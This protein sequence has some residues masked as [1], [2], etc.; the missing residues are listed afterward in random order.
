MVTIKDT[1]MVCGNMEVESTRSYIDNLYDNHE[2]K[3]GSAVVT[4]KN[5]VIGSQKQKDT[6]I[7]Q[8]VLARLI[9]LL[10]DPDI[11]T[12][13]KTDVVYILGSIT[14][15]SEANLKS[16]NDI[17]V[18]AILLNG[19]VSQDEKLVQASL[20]CLRS[21]LQSRDWRP[22]MDEPQFEL[23]GSRL[24]SPDQGCQLIFSDPTLVPHLIRLL[25]KDATHQIAVCDILTC[26]CRTPEQ[27]NLLVTS[28]VLQALSHVLASPTAHVQLAALQ[29]LAEVLNT[30]ETVAGA[31]LACTGREGKHLVS[32]VVHYTGRENSGSIQLAASRILT[33]LYRLGGMLEVEGVVTFR[34]L[35]CL[36]RSCKKEEAVDT[37]ILA[38]DTLAYLIEVSADL[39][40]VA[41]ISNHL[42]STMASYLRWEPEPQARGTGLSKQQLSR[43]ARRLEVRAASGKEMRRAAFKVFASLGANDEDIRK[44]IIDTEPLMDAVVTALDDPDGRVQMAA[45]RC[46]HSLSRSVQLLRTTF[47]DHTVWEPLMKILS[48]PNGKVESLVVASSTL[49]NLLLEFSP[50]KERILESGAVDLL[51]SLTQKYDPSL[52][53]NGVWGLMNMAFQSEQ[54]IKSQIMTT[55]GTDQVFRLLSDT[56]I[57]VVMKTLG[58]LRNLLSNKHHIDHITNIYGKQLMQAV[59]LVLESEHTA[60]VKEQ[61]LCILSN[62]ADGDTAKRLIVDNEDMLKK[63][64]SY[65]VHSNTKLQI[66]AV[67][68][69]LNLIWRNDEGSADRQMRLKEIGVFKILHQLLT[70][71]DSNLFDKVKLALQQLTM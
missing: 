15:G 60:D 5:A 49:C 7:E 16:L 23:R 48:Q 70:T 30:N 71:S 25:E 39:Q 32:Q 45:I 17:D 26:C 36:V 27:Q 4:L 46:L 69:I 37:R 34:V 52:R 61:A 14:N 59:V 1:T 42:I 40:R 53:L 2:D 11:P 33:Y 56:E 18:V 50:S 62:I 20:F 47:Q 54:R 21:M 10:V 9:H 12:R 3:V 22:Q 13:I 8:G 64:T 41:A 24:S 38:A 6:I 31:V 67:I 29:C 65:M 28:G 35:P 43:L 19:L 58:L 66:A 51:C 57:H 63:L 68:C 55:L 44:K